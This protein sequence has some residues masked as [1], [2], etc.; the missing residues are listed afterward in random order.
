M[1]D[2]KWGIK[3]SQQHTTYEAIVPVWKAADAHPAFSHAWLF[4]HFSPITGDTPDSDPK[5]RAKYDAEGREA[6]EWPYPWTREA[7]AKWKETH[8][9]VLFKSP[10]VFLEY[11]K[12]PKATAE[13]KTPDGW[14]R[15]TPQCTYKG[16]ETTTACTLVKNLPD[17]KTES[18]QAVSLPPGLAEK[19]KKEGRYEKETAELDAFFKRT[20]YPRA[21]RFYIIKWL[22]DMV[23]KYGV[24]GFRCDTA[25]HIGEGVWAELR[26]EAELAFAD[27]KK[28]NPGKVLDRNGFY[29]TG[30]VSGYNIS[31]GRLYDF[32]DKK[33]D[34]FA[35][36]FNSLINFDMKNE[37]ATDYESVFSKYSALLQNQLKG[38]SVLNYF[39]SHDDAD[40][41]DKDRKKPFEAGT[42][43]LLCPGATQIYYGDETARSLTIPGT[44]GDATLRSFMNWDELNAN[45]SRHGYKIQDVLSHWQKLGRFRRSHPAVGAGVH[46]ML[47]ATPYTF[48]REYRSGTYTDAV[49]V[50]LDMAAGRKEISVQGVFPDGTKLTDYYSGKKI[51]VAGGKAVVESGFGIVLLG[52]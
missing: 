2:V 4:D 48:K 5:L 13:T 12:N 41:F 47:S 15:T 39:T 42:K 25:K 26:K 10:G 18:N 27:W 21:A 45:I 8:G 31:A 33:V 23:R 51:T 36:G 46:T 14:V 43:L 35:N 3:T 40:S 38:K 24:D 19:W 7:A 49:V 50:G 34:F 32:G 11:Y 44:Q 16:Y 17:I 22:A 28:A 9:E 29:M 52:K 6:V 20:G 1:P 30:E 37:G